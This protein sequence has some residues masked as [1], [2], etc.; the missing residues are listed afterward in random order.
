MTRRPDHYG[1][2]TTSLDS[3]SRLGLT[4]FWRRRMQAIAALPLAPRCTAR[5]TLAGALLAAALIAAA[6][7]VDFAPAAPPQEAGPAA[8][9]PAPESPPRNENFIVRFTN[10]VE[11]ELIGV[12]ASPSNADS[13]QAPDGS[14]IPAPY[15]ALRPAHNK[16]ESPML[17]EFCWRWRGVDDPDIRTSWDVD[18]ETSGWGPIQPAGPDGNILKDLTAFVVPFNLVRPTCTLRFTVS[19]PGSKW[20]TFFQGQGGNV[21]ANINTPPGQ[22]PTGVTFDKPRAMDG[23]AFVVMGYKLPQ[24]QD[25]RL[26]AVDGAGKRHLGKSEF[27]GGMMGIRQLAVQ[28]P[29]L[30]PDDIRTWIV[31]QRTRLTESV[32]F[33]NVSVDP[34][35]PTIVQLLGTPAESGAGPNEPP[36]PTEFGPESEAVLHNNPITDDG[37]V[38]FDAGKVF[39]LDAAIVDEASM[40]WLKDHSVDVMGMLESESPSLVGFDLIAVPTE[41][42]NWDRVEELMEHIRGAKPMT[43]AVLDASGE[44][45]ATYFFQTREGARG[46]VQIVEVVPEKTIK[47]RYK[48]AK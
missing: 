38:D 16:W 10:G 23:G 14:P 39:K 17:R 7:L 8:A 35:T 22:E 34:E 4:A 24:D 6:P 33:R 1:P 9:D 3:S 36:P 26:I 41:P 2:W 25:A 20:Q 12:S 21:M 48:L 40:N 29:D 46:V 42:E 27:A 32:A 19:Y 37:L 30:K 18:E 44:L 43:P 11:L 31:E 28:F 45:P 15:K 5:R 47:I 13:W